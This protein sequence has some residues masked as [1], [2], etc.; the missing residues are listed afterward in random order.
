MNVPNHRQG[1]NIVGHHILLQIGFTPN[2][3][4]FTVVPNP[5][6]FQHHFLNA[7]RIFMEHIS[8]IKGFPDLLP[9]IL[10][11]LPL[12]K[13]IDNLCEAMGRFNECPVMHH[14]IPAQIDLKES[15]G[16]GKHGRTDLLLLLQPDIFVFFF[17]N[18]FQHSQHP[19]L[20]LVITPDI[21][22]LYMVYD[23]FFLVMGND[24]TFDFLRIAF[25]RRKHTPDFP[26]GPS[27]LFKILCKF[28]REIFNNLRYPYLVRIIIHKLKNFFIRIIDEHKL[29]G[30]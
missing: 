22:H 27:A 5:D 3:E 26:A 8:D 14:T 20:F 28:F 12:H 24:F 6:I 19:K 10:M 4:I 30:L 21:C 11:D 16:I 18:I 25:N 7:H 29:S 23:R 13:G 1:D 17:R 15:N 9:V 2:P